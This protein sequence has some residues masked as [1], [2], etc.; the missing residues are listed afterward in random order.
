MEILFA[1]FIATIVIIGWF[2]GSAF[3]C[4]F[5]TLPTLLLMLGLGKDSPDFASYCMVFLCIVWAPFL[6][7]RWASSR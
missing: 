3:F 1:L 2:A 4:V 5:L 7:R 6:L